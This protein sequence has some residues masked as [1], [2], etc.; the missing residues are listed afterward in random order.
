MNSIKNISCLAILLIMAFSTDSLNAQ[1]EKNLAICLGHDVVEGGRLGL[2][3][4]GCLSSTD[5]LFIDVFS[6]VDGVP[7]P[8]TLESQFLN[9]SPTGIIPISKGQ[10]TF[11]AVDLTFREGVLDC[12]AS[13]SSQINVPISICFDLEAAHH[14]FVAK[15]AALMKTLA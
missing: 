7:I 10:S 13:E 14:Q 15:M 8:F 1:T 2:V 5:P 4:T 9:S 12:T 3:G 6:G 11:T